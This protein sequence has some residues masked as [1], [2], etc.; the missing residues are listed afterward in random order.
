MVCLFVAV[1]E[2]VVPGRVQSSWS[3]S[4]ESFPV[5]FLV[6]HYGEILHRPLPRA[7]SQ[8]KIKISQKSFASIKREILSLLRKICL[9]LSKMAPNRGKKG[10]RVRF[11]RYPALPP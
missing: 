1:V 5:V 11:A 2:N 9:L 4:G 7:D 3:S 10:H 6:T 8:A